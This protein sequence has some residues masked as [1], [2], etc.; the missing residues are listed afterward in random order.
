MVSLESY[1]LR[2][3]PF[4]GEGDVIV[5]GAVSALPLRTMVEAG[6]SV[7]GFRGTVTPSGIWNGGAFSGKSL[8][9]AS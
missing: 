2:F 3:F 9:K 8:I 1:H 4:S 7:L 6:C 5:R